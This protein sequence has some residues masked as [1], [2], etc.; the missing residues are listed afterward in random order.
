L[1]SRTL[2]LLA[3]FIIALGAPALAQEEGPDAS[4]AFQDRLSRLLDRF[5]DD[6]PPDRLG[7]AIELCEKHLKDKPD[8][9]QA[10]LELVR[11]KL[12]H[13]DADTAREPVRIAAVRAEDLAASQPERLKE[14]RALRLVATRMAARPENADESEKVQKEIVALYNKLVETAGSKEAADELDLTERRRINQARLLNELGRTPPPLLLD[15][16][17]QPIQGSE[18]RDTE[19]KPVRLD[20]FLGKVLIVD[21]WSAKSEVYEKEVA[22]TLAVREKYKDKVEVLGI[23][24][25]NDRALLDAFVKKNNIPWRQVFSGKGPTDDTAI[26]WKVP[27]VRRFV[28]DQDGKVRFVD[29]TGEGLAA[30]L[31]QLVER[32]A[33]SGRK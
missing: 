25:D 6:A 12:A 11:L 21:F 1:V 4:T 13:G 26:S 7:R 15:Q 5:N 20:M 17:G 14:A 24:L 29:V 10:Q 8:D 18:R 22:N 28:I 30:A 33:K 19:G 16:K 2:L 27:G 23:S 9:A 32:P 31:K 3:S